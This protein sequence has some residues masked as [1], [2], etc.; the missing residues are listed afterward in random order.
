MSPHS[1]RCLP[2]VLLLLALLNASQPR[3]AA[4]AE[5]S[6]RVRV[7]LVIDTHARDLGNFPQRVGGTMQNLLTTGFEGRGN[8][9]TIDVLDGNRATPDRVI[10]YYRNL[11]T[12]STETLLFYYFGH[13]AIDPRNS[14]HYLAMQYGALFRSE[15]R[16]AM[17]AKR[18]RLAVLLTGCCSSYVPASRIPQLSGPRNFNIAP[19]DYGPN[20]QQI[21]DL[22]FRPRGLVDVTAT[23]PGTVALAGLFT[24]AVSETIYRKHGEVDLNRDGVLG[25]DEFLAH[26]RQKTNAKYVSLRPHS[27]HA[28]VRK[29]AYQLPH[30]FALPG[31]PQI[32]RK[33]R[34]EF[35]ERGNARPTNYVVTVLTN[36]YNVDLSY[37]YRWGEQGAWVNGK[38]QANSSLAHHI[39]YVPSNCPWLYI[40]FDSVLGDGQVTVTNYRLSGYLSQAKTSGK[41]Y[42]FFTRG[43]SVLDLGYNN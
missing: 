9:I 38:L 24:D 18:P 1:P 28:S 29:Q 16:A 20:W 31:S 10:S 2:Y 25:W 40:R 39:Q 37:Q 36:P 15:V 6:S 17:Q 19:L 35:P 43:P 14:E 12:N 42:Q 22:F 34:V 27:P 26:V 5:Y 23:S 4:S 33:P 11:Q 7:L 32:V 8:L 13:G 21:T 3:R 41:Q 30:A